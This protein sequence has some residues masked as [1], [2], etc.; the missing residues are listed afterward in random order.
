MKVTIPYFILA[1]MLFSLAINN[2]LYSQLS[3]RPHQPEL[4]I[5][6]VGFD[7]EVVAG[8]RSA[9]MLQIHN[10]EDEEVA[11]EFT[12]DVEGMVQWL[13]IIGGDGVIPPG[14][15]EIL[16]VIF[17]ARELLVDD[18][19][20]LITIQEAGNGAEHEI[21]VDVSVIEPEWRD[22]VYFGG[23]VIGRDEWRPLEITNWRPEELTITDAVSDNEEFRIEGLDEPRVV[24]QGETAHL[25]IF[26]NAAETGERSAEITLI[27][28]H[29]DREEHVV[30]CNTYAVEPDGGGGEGAINLVNDGEDAIRFWIEIEYITDP[31]RDAHRRQLR[32]VNGQAQSKCPHRDDPGD[33]VGWLDIERF[34]NTGFSWDHD[35]EAMWAT[36]WDPNGEENWLICYSY[37]N[38]EI[39]IVFAERDWGSPFGLVYMNGLLFF[40]EDQRVFGVDR[41]FNLAIEF[42]VGFNP[43]SIAN[44]TEEFLLVMEEDTRDVWIFDL[45]GNNLGVIEGIPNEVGNENIRKMTYVPNRDAPLWVT[46][47]GQAWQ[48]SIDWNNRETE[49]VQTFAIPND[50]ASCGI[51]HDGHNLW[52]G[53]MDQPFINVIYDGV[54]ESSTWITFES[55]EGEIEAG[56]DEN[57]FLMMNPLGLIDG[58]YVALLTIWRN[59]WVEP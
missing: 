9:A 24:P 42:E 13:S 53:M 38:R 36:Y 18:Y 55:T 41:D 50:D 44:A 35:R 31:Y 26:C 21:P 30:N 25:R 7:Q 6:P 49:L 54:I 27:T 52:I 14:E 19:Q 17:D 47:E 22:E 40:I 11:Y 16:R 48:L 12:V 33:V 39:E 59:D 57:I 43:I 5:D 29:P 1:S 51:G 23:S 3:Y 45:G 8:R 32:C 4:E 58:V 15:V 20:G 2:P 37:R 56:G 46:T 28:D 10:P 34:G